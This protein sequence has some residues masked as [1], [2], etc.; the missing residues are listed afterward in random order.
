MLKHPVTS[1]LSG[2]SGLALASAWLVSGPVAPAHAEDAPPVVT[3]VSER[4]TST[5]GG[6]VVTLTGSGFTD[7]ATV[8][9]GGRQATVQSAS[10]DRLV[11]AL[12]AAQPGVAGIQVETASG[13][14]EMD[15]STAISYLDPISAPRPASR[16]MPRRMV[17][18]QAATTLFVDP[19]LALCVNDTLGLAPTAVPTSR[20]LNGLTG[21][22]CTGRGISRLEGIA[23]LPSLRVVDLGDNAIS[24]PGPLSSLTKLTDLGLQDNA[25]SDLTPLSQLTGL[26]RLDLWNNPVASVDPLRGMRRLARLTIDSTRV[27]SLQ[28]L[29]SLT[30]L[31][32]LGANYTRVSDLTPLRGM[33]R[34][35]DLQLWHT[36]V[37]N[38]SPLSSLTSLVHLDVSATGVSSLAP[39]SR[40]TRLETL[41]AEDCVIADAT[42]L[43]R[44]TRLYSL[45]LNGNRLT[46]VAPLAG[47]TRLQ[48]LFLQRNRIADLS[49]LRRL[50]PN[51][52]EAQG[53][54]AATPVSTGKAISFRMSDRHGANLTVTGPN[55]RYS[56]GRITYTRAS[57]TV[58]S[59]R[60]SDG[61]FS[62]T[63]LTT[64]TYNVKPVR[65]D[66]T[67]DGI[68]DI[69][70]V[71]GDSVLRAFRG[72]PRSGLYPLAQPWPDA[73]T[74]TSLTQI[75][76]VNGDRRSDLLTRER[77]GRLLMR[78]GLGNGYLGSARQVGSRWNS[79]DLITSGGHLA[80]GSASMLLARQI[81]NGTLVRY[82]LTS[83]GLTGTKV[84]GHGW[85]TMRAIAGISDWN[86][87]RRDDILAV[88][89]D[90]TLWL[91]TSSA[92]GT[93]NR[94]VQ[95]GRGWTGFTAMF[96][97]GDLSGDGRAD[98]VGV[99]RDG[100][101]IAYTTGRTGFS[102]GRQIGRGFQSYR[103][104]G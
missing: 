71:T 89:R 68:A 42:P 39:V 64:C 41:S 87:D 24:D 15:S 102:A 52:I 62:G 55:A 93:P 46:N 76:D 25:V 21:L 34:L 103:L 96:S 70:G 56:G 72:S 6:D 8:N 101:V 94:G 7:D 79:M 65:G 92:A 53:Q 67:G 82:T 63:V 5:T 77:D 17:Q 14:S 44:L 69:Y 73:G 9:V 50:T 78:T 88:R 43:A 30:S 100:T 18:P 45:N 29:S 13:S 47:L 97:P 33:T 16:V 28:P 66:V 19:N 83:S 57:T 58:L 3:T 1:F 10:S 22:F 38:I 80:G 36:G 20:Q 59:F 23:Q 95:V 99:R 84:I 35:Q 90:G 31:T 74:V 51:S 32:T 81:S 98:L 61:Q 40:L 54:Q 4:A 26:T 48:W 60:S 2:L 27:S 49:S 12:P 91:Y 104:I 37:S 11:I 85:G 75:P 86:G